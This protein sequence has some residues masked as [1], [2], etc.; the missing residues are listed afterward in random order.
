MLAQTISKQRA[1]IVVSIEHRL[2]N[3]SLV[4][5]IDTQIRMMTRRAYGFHSPGALIARAMLSLPEL[6]PRPPRLPNFH[7][8]PKRQNTQ[9]RFDGY[10]RIMRLLIATA[11]VVLGALFIAASRFVA[12][13]FFVP[14][15]ADKRQSSFLVFLGLGDS[16]P[17]RLYRWFSMMTV[18]LALIG[19]GIGI[20]AGAIEV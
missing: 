1:G 20:V 9:K 7:Q 17:A 4:E 12:D 18:G 15:P 14:K 3:A 6:C 2:F 16:Y 13:R 5:A 8:P 19:V 10:K 11:F